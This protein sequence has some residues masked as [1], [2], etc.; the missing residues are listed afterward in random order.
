MNLT[1]IR[2]IVRMERYAYT[3]DGKYPAQEIE[4]SWTYPTAH[5]QPEIGKHNKIMKRRGKTA[6]RGTEKIPR[7]T[8]RIT[9]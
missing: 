5:R 3:G 9:G 1:A 8:V 7:Y 6:I 2:N 4:R